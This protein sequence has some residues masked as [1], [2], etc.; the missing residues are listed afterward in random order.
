MLLLYSVSWS[1]LAQ[2]KDEIIDDQ[3]YLSG[4]IISGE[5]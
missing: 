3:I 1:T 4:I 5:I 2:N